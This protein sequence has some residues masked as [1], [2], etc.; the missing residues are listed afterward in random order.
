MPVSRKTRRA[1]ARARA[2]A[3]RQQWRTLLW[4]V[5]NGDE[6]ANV[7]RALVGF[8]EK[9][10]QFGILLLRDTINSTIEQRPL[11]MY[12]TEYSW[13]AEEPYRLAAVDRDLVRT[14][15]RS[16]IGSYCTVSEVSYVA[17]CRR[18]FCWISSSKCG[19]PCK[20]SKYSVPRI[21]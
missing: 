18:S 1:R 9:P 7:W 13:R 5:F 20:R 4:N 10:S 6:S 19:K 3:A 12:Y 8:M 17:F 21:Y 2:R 16:G 14:E 11:Q 15:A